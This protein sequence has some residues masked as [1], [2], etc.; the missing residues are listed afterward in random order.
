MSKIQ[1]QLKLAV[2][3]AALAYVPDQEIIGI[4]T[5]ST[6]NCFID[7][8]GDQQAGKIRA[9][10]ASSIA[11]ADR[12]RHWGIEVI[13]LNSVDKLPVYIDGADEINCQLHMIK[14]GGGALTREKILAAASTDFV[15]IA[16][17]SKLVEHLGTFPLPIEVI[18]MACNYV[19]RKMA[20]FG[21]KPIVREGKI[22]DNG[23]VIIDVHNLVI[24]DPV[25]LET[26]INQIA[27]V[28][29]CGLFAH[30]GADVL[31]LGCNSGVKTLLPYSHS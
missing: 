27:G 18:P 12:L 17:S 1:N 5:G 8:L 2:A 28:V 29:S 20:S 16:D 25:S 7:L 31:L 24:T 3:K 6:V 14:G 10:V 13:D 22:T 4:G 11:S 15:C 21:G 9:A 19:A 30:R 26:E 23:N